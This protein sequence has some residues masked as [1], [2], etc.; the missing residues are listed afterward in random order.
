[1]REGGGGERGDQNDG[2]E[3]KPTNHRFFS[4]K[5]KVFSFSNRTFSAR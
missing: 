1:M 3:M 2:G 5:T 4:L